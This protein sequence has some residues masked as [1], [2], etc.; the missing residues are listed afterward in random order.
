[1]I[2]V[3]YLKIVN[4]TVAGSILWII[5]DRF[6]LCPNGHEVVSNHDGSLPLW[7]ECQGAWEPV[8]RVRFS[9]G[10]DI[11]HTVHRHLFSYREKEFTDNLIPVKSPVDLATPEI[12][13][14]FFEGDEVGL[15]V[16]KIEGVAQSQT[17]DAVFPIE[18]RD[19]L[20]FAKC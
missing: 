7:S 6:W 15:F 11:P 13:I 4:V 10:H 2:P 19:H 20:V 8:L 5:T 1:M 9:D 17:R 16:A 3:K 12:E 14:L 18:C